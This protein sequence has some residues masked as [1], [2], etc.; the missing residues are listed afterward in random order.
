MQQKMTKKISP[1]SSIFQRLVKIIGSILSF[2]SEGKC[3]IQNTVVLIGVHVFEGMWV[4]L[5]TDTQKN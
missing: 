3:N 2:K 4:C 5:Q 1:L